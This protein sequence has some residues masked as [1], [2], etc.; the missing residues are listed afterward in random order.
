MYNFG[1][2]GTPA[3][4][5]PEHF[6]ELNFNGDHFQSEVFSLG[7]AIL[8]ML[9]HKLP[10]WV[11]IIDELI[12][13]IDI[14]TMRYKTKTPEDIHKAQE[15]MKQCVRQNINN[16][17]QFHNLRKRKRLKEKLTQGEELNLLLFST[18]LVEPGE[19]IT[20]EKLRIEIRKLLISNPPRRKVVRMLTPKMKSLPDAQ[21][22]VASVQVAVQAE[23]PR[24]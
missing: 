4:T 2:T 9:D 12:K 18:L 11:D 14:T 23:A 1:F 19:R 17:P 15:T 6:A 3:F 22:L 16:N 7:V 10:E 24:L 5:S 20:I 13:D 8:A 21:S